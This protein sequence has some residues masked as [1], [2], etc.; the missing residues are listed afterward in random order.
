MTSAN[1]KEKLHNERDE[2]LKTPSVC[3]IF[4]N[5]GL[6]HQPLGPFPSSTRETVWCSPWQVI[7]EI[8][9]NPFIVYDPVAKVIAEIWSNSHV[10]PP[11]LITHKQVAIGIIKSWLERILE[12]D[13][14]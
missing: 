7:S 13:I 10:S 11:P 12:S 5:C 9:E 14:R 8:A 2:M 3:E 1:V 6:G 4:D